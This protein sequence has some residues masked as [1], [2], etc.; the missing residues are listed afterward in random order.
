MS[1]KILTGK[2]N[3]VSMQENENWIPEAEAIAA[4]VGHPPGTPPGLYDRLKYVAEVLQALGEDGATIEG[5]C[6]AYRQAD[7]TVHVA[8]LAAETIVG[9]SEDAAI[10]VEDS[11]LSRQHFRLRTLEGLWEV[12]DLS[13]TNG[14]RVNGESMI[15]EQPRSLCSGDL[16]EAGSTVFVFIVS[17]PIS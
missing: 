8:A 4:T 10:P 2:G 17:A 14:T 15:V 7:R 11:R 12:E 16:I 6:L 1:H 9:R 13:S 5:A 3:T